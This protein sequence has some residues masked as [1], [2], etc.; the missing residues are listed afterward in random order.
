[1]GRG[2]RSASGKKRIAGDGRQGAL[3]RIEASQGVPA[4]GGRRGE[5]GDLHWRW[6]ANQYRAAIVDLVAADARAMAVRLGPAYA[7]QADGLDQAVLWSRASLTEVYLYV[8]YRYSIV[9]AAKP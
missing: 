7:V 3:E 6:S 8:P 5:A 1:M 4:W 2:E 9:P